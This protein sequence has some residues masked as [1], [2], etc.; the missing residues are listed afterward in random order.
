M[1]DVLG[2][3]Y[4]L[5]RKINEGFN[6]PIAGKVMI[7]KDELLSVI[8]EIENILPQ[9][10]KKANWIVNERQRI[11]IEAQKE[12]ENIIKEAEDRINKM[13]DDSEISRMAYEKA[14]AIVSNARKNAREIR[15]GA[16]EYAEEVLRNLYTYL[17]KTMSTVKK[18][19]DQLKGIDE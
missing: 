4:E 2:L 12:G 8:D 3:L 14:D 7:N 9:E 16:N 1:D 11:L 10:I 18:G 17:E 5:R 19:I 15:I 6:V 13:V